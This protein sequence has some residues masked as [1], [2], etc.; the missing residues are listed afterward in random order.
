M[1][2]SERWKNTASSLNAGENFLKEIGLLEC[3]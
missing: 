1:I 2:G 3:G